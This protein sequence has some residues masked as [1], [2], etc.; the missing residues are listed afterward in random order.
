MPIVEKLMN[1]L[2]QRY[3]KKRGESIYYAMEA[4]GKG[5]FA[6]GGKHRKQHEDFVARNGLPA[7]VTAKKK[8]AA[9][10]KKRRASK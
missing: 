4:E 8:P 5:P 2:V 7:T 1:N 9:S 6:E 3:G 10:S